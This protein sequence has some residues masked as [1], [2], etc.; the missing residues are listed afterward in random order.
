MDQDA[1]IYDV[2]IVGCGPSG[3]TL[4]NLL[5]MRGLSVAIFDRD[6]EVF[7]V[8]RAMKLDAECTR[9]CQTLGILDR[10]LPEHATPYTDHY[11]VN[12]QRRVLM[13]M[14]TRPAPWIEGQPAAGIMFH[15]PAFESLLR[16][17]FRLDDRVDTYLGYD[18]LEVNGSGDLATVVAKAADAISARVFRGRYVVGADGGNSL[19]RRTITQGRLDLDYQRTW[20]VI[21]ILVHDQALWDSLKQ[22]SEFK[23]Q[24]NGA[25]VFVKG[26]HNHV[27]FDFEAGERAKTF[28]E[29]DAR[30]MIGEYFDT[31]SIE[32]LRLASY[33]F[34]AGIPLQWR[35][36]RLFIMGD[37]AHQTSP[38]SGQGLNMGLRDAENLAFKFDLVLKDLAPPELLSTYETERWDHC[39]GLIEGASRR[40]KMISADTRI[41]VMLRSLSFWIGR[42]SKNL[43]LNLTSR[44][45]PTTPYDKG[46]LGSHEL[47]GSRFMQPRVRASIGMGDD[48]Q[49][50]DDVIGPN[51]AIVSREKVT[52]VETTEQWFTGQLG[53]VVVQLGIDFEVIGD[54]LEQWM[55]KHEIQN[56][57]VRPDRHIFDIG[58]N[59]DELID[60]LR[61]QLAAGGAQPTNTHNRA[62][63]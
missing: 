17:D 6:E 44:Q 62:R 53:G 7:P 63:G 49:L 23:C 30:A 47:A 59:P 34:Y 42:M 38:F 50:L 48:E 54:R 22:G 11:F 24:P 10:L 9:T 27:R 12:E 41:A 29:Q 60:A 13:H 35:K 52:L 28:T 26:H 25:V 1:K 40:G 39:V 37:A 57:L 56:L 31:S 15:Q 21:D 16:D 45:S 51:F 5:R 2:L 8:P 32:F 3:A 36:E 4:A 18:V 14:D 33:E 61:A 19:V 20:I 46:L 55:D 43:A 58:N